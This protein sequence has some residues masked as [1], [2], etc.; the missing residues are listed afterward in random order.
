MRND[1]T[2]PYSKK[3]SQTNSKP[4]RMNNT[5]NTLRNQ[6]S[7]FWKPSHSLIRFSMPRWNIHAT[8]AIGTAAPSENSTGIA[9]PYAA[10]HAIGTIAPKYI[11]ALY[12]QNANANTSPKR[13]ALRM[14]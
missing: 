8:S 10:L 13:N 9:Q 2:L 4:V 12:G 14:E 1:A 6:Y 5:A 3:N 11:A 7:N